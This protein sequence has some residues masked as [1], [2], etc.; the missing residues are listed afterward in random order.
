MRR[1][2]LR[3]LK[4]KTESILSTSGAGRV[5]AITKNPGRLIGR[6]RKEGVQRSLDLVRVREREI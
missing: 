2:K 4:G 6:E 3:K 5:R 1:E